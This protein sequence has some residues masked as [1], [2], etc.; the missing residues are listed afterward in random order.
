MRR[1][2]VVDDTRAAAFVL[3]R[4]L[5]TLGQQVFIAND[6]AMALDLARIERPDVIISD[7]AMPKM[8]GYE[9]ARALRRDPALSHIAMVALT[10]FGQDTDREHSLN[11]GFDHHLVKPVSVESLHQLFASLPAPATTP[12]S[13]SFDDRS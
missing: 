13:V 3:G 11:A 12:K 9:L 8:D 1:V 6:G 2:L 4:L 7:I 5:E 10:G